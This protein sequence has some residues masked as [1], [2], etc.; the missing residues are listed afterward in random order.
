M[1]PQRK[2]KRRRLVLEKACFLASGLLYNLLEASL[3]PFEASF[4]HRTDY[5]K[6][7]KIANKRDFYRAESK[8]YLERVVVNGELH[9]QVTKKGRGALEKCFPL[10]KLCQKKWDGRWRV[11]VFDICEKSRPKRDR[12]RW[13]LETLGFG[14]LQKSVW[15]NPYKVGKE[16]KETLT[17]E[18]IIKGVVVFEG[19]RIFGEDEADL[20]WR[21]WK[22]DKLE[23]EYQE[24]VS[25]LEGEKLSEQEMINWYLEILQNDPFLPED[26]LPSNWV[27]LAAAKKARKLLRK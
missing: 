14:M 17:L 12:L 5:K 25:E 18:G 16:V 11:V 21:V 4:Q 15:I 2:G 23:T 22:L 1:Y 26:L 27:G 20:A 13:R 10:I 6:L 24:W 8:G 3:A 19:E 7:K 9:Y